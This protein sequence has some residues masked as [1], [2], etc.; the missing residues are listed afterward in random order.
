MLTAFLRKIWVFYPL[1]FDLELDTKDEIKKE[2]TEHE[3]IVE[4]EDNDEDYEGDYSYDEDESDDEDYWKS[5]QS[6]NNNNKNRNDVKVANKNVSN[7]QK[8]TLQP[9]SKQ[10]GKFVNKIKLDKY[11]GTNFAD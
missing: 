2:E 3:Q 10:F 6:N 5:K 4:D 7:K 9:Q 11:E 1:Y 8:T